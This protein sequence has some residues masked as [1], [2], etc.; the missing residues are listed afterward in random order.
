MLQIKGKC[1]SS[2]SISHTYSFSR[3][4]SNPSNRLWPVR[5]VC[6]SFTKKNRNLLS[7][8]IYHVLLCH[9][10]SHPSLSP[11]PH[12]SLS[13]YL[14][15]PLWL[16]SC[17]YFEPVSIKW[18]NVFFAG[19]WHSVDTMFIHIHDVSSPFSITSGSLRFYVLLIAGNNLI[20]YKFA[21]DIKFLFHFCSDY[22]AA[23]T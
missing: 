17:L 4:R 8:L 11:P 9:S 3:I 12:L 13:L 21:D 22:C 18:I 6:N 15:I 5:L 20:I 14:S 16:I 23:F 19:Y 7:S 1:E 2:L 10:L